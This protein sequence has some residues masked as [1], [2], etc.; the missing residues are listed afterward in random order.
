LIKDWKCT[1]EKGEREKK[2]TP[3]RKLK[4]RIDVPT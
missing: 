3:G 2:D 1:Q 4:N